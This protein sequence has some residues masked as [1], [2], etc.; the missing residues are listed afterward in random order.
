M[1]S[2]LTPSQ[3]AASIYDINLKALWDKGYYNIIIDVDNTI[4]AWNH[5]RMSPSLSNWIQ[6]VKDFGFKICLL[7]NNK[8]H[9]VQ[10]FAAELGVIAAPTGGKPSVK[11]FQSALAALQST[12]DNT[13]V[14]G[15]QIFTDILGGN[16]AGLYTILVDP[17]D[18]REFAGTKI[19][20]LLERLLVGR[21]LTCKSHPKQE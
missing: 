1:R 13:I 19:N 14:I 17:V 9:K 15:D 18:T 11:A 3:T 8:Q 20:R 5:Y 21:R 7:S 6:K 4:T 10:K 16:R 2:V 12:K